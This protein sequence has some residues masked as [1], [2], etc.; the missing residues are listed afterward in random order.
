MNRKMM[1]YV[2]SWLTV[3]KQIKT[4]VFGVETNFY[5]GLSYFN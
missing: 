3:Q 2:K 4:M 5:E 1:Q